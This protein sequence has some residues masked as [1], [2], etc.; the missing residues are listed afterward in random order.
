MLNA[1]GYLV[2]SRVLDPTRLIGVV[3]DAL[4]DPQDWSIRQLAVTVGT[5]RLKHV[6]GLDPQAI[7]ADRPQDPERVKT[8]T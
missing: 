3:G 5:A 1:I 2:G 4:L 7:H 6:V 8:L